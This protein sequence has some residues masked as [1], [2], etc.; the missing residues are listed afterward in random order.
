MRVVLAAV[1]VIAVLV[2]QSGI[3]ASSVRP[4]GLVSPGPAP[5]RVNLR[6]ATGAIS[7]AWNTASIFWFGQATNAGSSSAD[8]VDVRLTYDSQ[9]LYI[10]ATIVDYYLWYDPTGA[11]DPRTYDAFAIYLDTDG[12]RGSAPDAN[13]Y[14]VVS[15]LSPGGCPNIPA[16]DTP[17]W[18][19]QGRGT[20][21]AWDETWQPTPAWTA[22][23]GCRYYSSGPNN[24]SDADAGWATTITI[25]WATLGRSGP[26]RPGDAW[27]M[28]AVLYNRNDPPPAGSG[29]PETWP[30]TF[31]ASSPSSW[32]QLVFDPPPYQ[33]G[34]TSRGGTV[35]IQRGL[36]GSVTD[37][38][39]GGGGSCSGGTV[40]NGANTAHPGD[41][42]LFVQNQADVSDFPCFS[43]S[44][45]Q[46]DLSP[47]PAGQVIVSATLQIYQFGSSGTTGCGTPKPS[48][49]QLFAVSDPWNASTLTWNNA[50]LAAQNFPGTWVNP[51]TIPPPGIAVTWDA[52]AL[53]AEAYAAGRP[54]NLALYAAD[55]ACNS[56]KYFVSSNVGDWDASG[57]PSLTVTWGTAVPVRSRLFVPVIYR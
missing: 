54:A 51:V 57:R 37:A 21:S 11:A 30:E 22:I 15:G 43:K 35:T 24:N 7:D 49:I 3:A 44:Y 6:P 45:L 39:V 40:D 52:T 9:A 18:H 17:R 55:T 12:D 19:R 13:D 25:P 5:R 53:V 46:F 16:S 41:P 48:W 28:G 1:G 20:G 23:N 26:P 50:P 32:A 56:G 4:A 38:W 42:N 47:V 27:G 33:P 31:A 34:L 10:W 29:A 8:Y 14:F 36:I 2:I